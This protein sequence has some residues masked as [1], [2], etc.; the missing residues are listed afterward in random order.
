M[1]D[2][3]PSV[4]FLQAPGA[5]IKIGL[6]HVAFD[7]PVH[8]DSFLLRGVARWKILAASMPDLTLKK[9]NRTRSRKPQKFI[10]SFTAAGASRM[11]CAFREETILYPEEDRPLE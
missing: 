8:E 7:G 11:R 1:I 6:A 2:K 9:L 4:D 5:P 10:Q 3:P